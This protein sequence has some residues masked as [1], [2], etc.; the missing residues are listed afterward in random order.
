MRSRQLQGVRSKRAVIVPGKLDALHLGHQA[1]VRQASKLGDRV[2]VLTFPGMAEV[3]GW[4]PRR[5]ICSS[6][7]RLAVFEEWS[8]AFGASVVGH[9]IP[10]AGVRRLPPSDFILKLAED[11]DSPAVS[12]HHVAF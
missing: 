10:F 1:L 5:P 4:E 9:E 6:K 7:C 3:L 2:F 11:F 12:H 8:A